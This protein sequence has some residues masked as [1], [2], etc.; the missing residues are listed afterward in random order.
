MGSTE[1]CPY[2][3]IV[4]TFHPDGS[5]LYSDN[6]QQ[7]GGSYTVQGQ[8][9]SFRFSN[10]FAASLNFQIEGEMLVLSDGA[11]LVRQSQ[12]PQGPQPVPVGGSIEGTWAVQ[13]GQ[14]VLIM[15]FMNGICGFNFNGNQAYGPYT[16]QGRHL[17]VQ[18]NNGQTLDV[19]VT[20]Q[21]DTLLFSNG[22]RLQRKAM[23]NVGGQAAPVVQQPVQPGQVQGGATP[24]EGSWGVLLPNGMRIV[25]TFTGSTYTVQH[26]GTTVET[27]TFR[28][29]GNQ[30]EYTV[31][32][33]QMPG[34][35]GVNLWQV[36]GNTFIMTVPNGSSTQFT[37]M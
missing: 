15:M 23:P 32:S 9:L 34:Q 18:F 16:L 12:A 25:F 3:C 1:S 8:T 5:L 21:G 2:Y 27:G 11:R 19:E 30:L 28:L 17:H 13:D 4:F 33:G 35:R 14:N 6:G 29:N 22:T 10:G 24:L 20:L 31:T 37:R 26:N 36:Q 7:I